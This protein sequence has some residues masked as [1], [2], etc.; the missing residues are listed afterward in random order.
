[1]STEC[2]FCKIASGEIPTEKILEN[3][4]VIAFNDINP[5]APVHVLII[6]REHIPTFNDLTPEH[7]SII[8]KMFDAAR[9]IAKQLEIGESGYRTIINC[10]R[11]S[12][13][14]VFHLH[15]HILGGKRLGKM[16]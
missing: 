16:G 1:M 11:D 5:V 14:E 8:A 2:I 6:P 12:G 15:M 10:N 7:D 3:D 13:Q 4:D 9:T